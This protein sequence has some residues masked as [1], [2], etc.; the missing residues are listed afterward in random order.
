MSRIRE[1][2]YRY[3]LKDEKLKIVKRV[4]DDYNNICSSYAL[5]YKISI[6]YKTELGF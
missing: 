3:W 2:S 1:E 5:N 6:Q 4:V